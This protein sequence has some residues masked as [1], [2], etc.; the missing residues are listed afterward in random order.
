MFSVAFYIFLYRQGRKK[1]RHKKGIYT[2]FFTWKPLTVPRKYLE[3]CVSDD[4]DASTLTLSGNTVVAVYAVC[5]VNLC[6]AF[7]VKRKGGATRTPALCAP[8]SFFLQSLAVRQF[9][10]YFQFTA[11]SGNKFFVFAK[12]EVIGEYL[13]RKILLLLLGTSCQF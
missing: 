11:E 9:N 1:G 8:F 6:L 3:R 13:L 2:T 10:G 7:G 5:S 4:D 12:L